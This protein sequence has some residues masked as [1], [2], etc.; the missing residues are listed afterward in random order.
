[1]LRAVQ[2]A[3]RLNFTIEPETY[4]AICDNVKL[5]ETV[6]AERIAEEL[7]KLLIKADKPSVGLKLMQS[8]GMLRIRLAGIA[9]NRRM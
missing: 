9:E 6:S 1:M 2:F 4:Q 7:N 8:T 5:I 3:A